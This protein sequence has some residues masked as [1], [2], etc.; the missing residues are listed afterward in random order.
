MFS[1]LIWVAAAAE[2]IVDQSVINMSALEGE[3]SWKTL[4]KTIQVQN[5]P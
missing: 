2:L 1:K 4:A 3:L 5:I